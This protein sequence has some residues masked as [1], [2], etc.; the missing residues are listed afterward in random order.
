MK[1][2]S[3]HAAI[4][5]AIV[6][7]MTGCA[8][9]DRASPI[10]PGHADFASSLARARTSPT[11][12]Q[13]TEYALPRPQSAPKSIA[14][15]SDGALWFTEEQ[16]NQIGR[17][18]TAGAITTY[19]IPAKNAT[20]WGIA[21]G[22]DGALW[23]TEEIPGNVGR[24]TTAGHFNEYHIPMSSSP[25][26]LGITTNP[27]GALWFGSLFG[28]VGRISVSGQFTLFPGAGPLD[29][30]T[31]G[32][33][34]ALWFANGV[35][36]RGG[37]ARM[38]TTG[39]LTQYPVGGSHVDQVAVGPDHRIWFTQHFVCAVNRLGAITTTG[40]L[41]H[42][43]ALRCSGP[44]GIAAGPDGAMW[45]TEIR[46]DHVD[47][48]TLNGQITRYAVPTS[49]AGPNGITAGPDGAMCF[50][51]QHANKIGRIQAI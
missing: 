27:D 26:P 28:S 24:L 41:Q 47:R 9:A 22:P 4:A 51:E 18:S 37:I 21:A 17:I 39:S 25:E 49:G 19:E 31:S 3:C 16:S 44:A 46:D 10:L 40:Q 12:G 5:T 2:T 11:V 6:V 43:P 35:G 15:G 45:F 29:G 34:G 32:P 8:A 30:I 36:S 38:T 7:S 48:I 14:V 33:D 50:T 20:P 23:F 13:I 42:Y 1:F